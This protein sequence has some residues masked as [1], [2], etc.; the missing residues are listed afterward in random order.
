M[1][2]RQFCQ[3]AVGLSEVPAAILDKIENLYLEVRSG[4][5]VTLGLSGANSPR[6]DTTGLL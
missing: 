1:S 5:V 3:V 2:L 6:W 4:P